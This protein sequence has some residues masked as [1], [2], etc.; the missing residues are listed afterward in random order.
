MDSIYYTHRNQYKTMRK[1]LLIYVLALSLAINLILTSCSQEKGKSPPRFQ[2]WSIGIYTGK[3][4]LDLRT[5]PTTI[6]PVLEASDVTDRDARF[7]ADP[8]MVRKAGS[9]YMFFE[10]LDGTTKQ[11]DIGFAESID[12][13]EWHY[14][15]VVLDEPFHLSYPHVFEHNGAFY[16]VPE[17]HSKNA[18][19]LY[20]A[21]SF[22]TEWEFVGNL[23]E[24]KPFR[25]PSITRF[26]G[27]WWM[28]AA[29][30]PKDTLDLYFADDMLGPWIEHPKSPIVRSDPNIARPGGRMIVWQNSLV[31]F[32]QDCDPI[33]GNSVRAFIITDLTKTTYSEKLA[34]IDPILGPSGTGW[35]QDGMHQIDTHHAAD[36]S[37]IA[38]VD[39]FRMEP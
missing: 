14:R 38:C 16:M 20:Q 7:V 19:R 10:I 39:G 8:F 37:W 6:N 36:Q 33:Y 18:I 35:N 17:S 27:T 34:D 13:L 3:N 26:N 2:K 11:G 32:A 5:G 31:R 23:I 30:T 21:T 24:G 28:I 15:Q 9:W 29:S 22:P 12:G 25:D 1:A 4:L